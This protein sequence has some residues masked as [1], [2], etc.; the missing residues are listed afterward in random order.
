MDSATA[1]DTLE[2]S[3]PLKARCTSCSIVEG[4][5]WHWIVTSKCHLGLLR[6][7]S[8]ASANCPNRLIGN[9]HLAPVSHILGNCCQL[10]EANLDRDNVAMMKIIILWEL[11]H[12]IGDPSLALLKFFT[13]ARKDI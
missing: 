3:Q 8:L 12:L 9:H 2:D 5:K 11:L 4:R 10:A 1:G 6:C 7:G 13:N